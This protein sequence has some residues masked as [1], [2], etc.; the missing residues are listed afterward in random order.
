M[1]K[2]RIDPFDS[3][4]E[5]RYAAFRDMRADAPIHDTEGGQRFVVGQKAVAEG[6]KSVESFVGSFGNTGRAAEE[7]TVMAAIPE[8]RHGKIR[9]PAP[10]TAQTDPDS[11][12]R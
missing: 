2:A 3:K 5:N 8:P 12:Q 6:L 4:S 9:K 1:K 10:A 7:D 11:Q